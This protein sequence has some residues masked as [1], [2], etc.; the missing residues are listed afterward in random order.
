MP[1]QGPEEFSWENGGSTGRFPP[2]LPEDFSLWKRFME[3][4]ESFDP[5]KVCTSVAWNSSSGRTWRH[6]GNYNSTRFLK[7][8]AIL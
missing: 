8:L 6:I 2:L 3:S 4:I 1:R 5:K 7:K